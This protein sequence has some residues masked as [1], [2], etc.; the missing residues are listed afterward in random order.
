MTT[1]PVME[2]NM[3]RRN[4]LKIGGIIA[5]GSAMGCGASLLLPMARSRAAVGSGKSPSPRWG[6]V[7]DLGKCRKGCTACVEACRAEN[8]VARFGDES[9]D[10]YWMQKVEVKRKHPAGSPEISVP[11]MCNHCEH[12]P[13]VQVCPTR[14]SYKRPDG[15]V[16]IDYHRCIGC[17]YCL[18]ACPYDARFFNFRENDEWPN[19]DYPQRRHGVSE[20]CNFCAHL[21]DKGEQPACVTAC[22]QANR[23]ALTFGNLDDPDAD[24]TKL[25]IKTQPRGI[26]EDLGTEPNVLYVGL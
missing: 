9:R 4:V 7:V 11:L 6:M 25:I 18:I 1:E 2:M 17:R 22:H 8:N 12:P 26:R 24:I 23:G 21:V 5:A 14:A 16:I 20:A 15:I 13:C 3:H 19:K 10:P